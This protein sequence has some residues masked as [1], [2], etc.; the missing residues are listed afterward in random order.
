MKFIS[1]IKKL[2]YN[3]LKIFVIPVVIFS[4][5]L[6]VFNQGIATI[7]SFNQLHQIASGHFTNWHPFF[8]TFIEMLCLKIY[9]STLSIEI[10]QILVF[11]TMWTAI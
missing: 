5:Y 2:N 1:Q 3:D 7:D 9:P 11:S 4:V 10:F 8:H 6:A